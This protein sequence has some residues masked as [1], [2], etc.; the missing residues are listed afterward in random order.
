[1]RKNTTGNTESTCTESIAYTMYCLCSEQNYPKQKESH[2]GTDISAKPFLNLQLVST[3][4]HTM[5]TYSTT[6]KTYIIMNPKKVP[7]VKGLLK[8]QKLR[9]WI[10]SVD[11]WPLER[12]VAKEYKCK[13]R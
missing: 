4:T 10:F 13:A 3:G 6:C 11:W 7:P 5:Y 9:D 1:M 12:Q 2:L 8:K